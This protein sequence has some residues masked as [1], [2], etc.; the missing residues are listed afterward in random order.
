M[1]AQTFEIDRP[2]GRVS[3]TLEV[4]AEDD[5][6]ICGIFQLSGAVRLR[7]KAWLGAVRAEVA[8]IEGI[9]RA[10]GCSQIRI[11]GRDWSRV[12]PDYQPFAGI[13]N[14]LMKRL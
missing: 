7:P 6:C 10:A 2:V 13:P 12:L 5:Q 8:R 11:G 3:I 9:A 1:L 4:F 14:G